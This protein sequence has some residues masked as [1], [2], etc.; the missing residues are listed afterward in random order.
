MAP[1]CLSMTGPALANMAK[2]R[3]RGMAPVRL[4]FIFAAS[5]PGCE[6]QAICHRYIQASPRGSRPIRSGSELA[7]M[8]RGHIPRSAICGKSMDC[9]ASCRES[10]RPIPARSVRPDCRLLPYTVLSPALFFTGLNFFPTHEMDV[11]A[12]LSFPTDSPPQKAHSWLHKRHCNAP[13]N[14]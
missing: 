3:G 9:R 4:E 14:G 11:S 7:R 1:C 2:A 10:G 5:P 13:V 12:R 8:S 6:Y